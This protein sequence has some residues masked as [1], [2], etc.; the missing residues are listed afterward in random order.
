[1]NDLFWRLVLAPV[2][3][4]I[5]MVIGWAIG[6]WR[7]FRAV[8]ELGCGRRGETLQMV[9]LWVDT[10]GDGAKRL[11]S[12][13][14]GSLSLEVTVPN[15]V[16]RDHIAK[17]MSTDPS[18]SLIPMDG[19]IGSATLHELHD[20]LKRQ[21]PKT[22]DFELERW[23]MAPVY[24]T[25]EGLDFQSPAIFLVRLDDLAVFQ[26]FGMVRDML[27]RHGAEGARILTLIQICK[28]FEAQKQ[29]FR[30][31]RA[32]GRTTRD[33]EQLWVVELPLDKRHL[34]PDPDLVASGAIPGFR[35]VSWERFATVL[36]QMGFQS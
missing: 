16:I 29:A 3:V 32:A 28:A 19:K 5:G 14:L 11:L 15:P 34:E 25:Y 18:T 17:N 10:A 12:R 13:S 24:E 31:A 26:N 1:M 4:V 2:S 20:L 8:Q 22:G 6:R 36:T 23:V 35:K 30:D 9:Y 33:L 7:H 27:V 21:A